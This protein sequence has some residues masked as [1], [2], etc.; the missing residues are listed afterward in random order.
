MNPFDPAYAEPGAPATAVAMER[1][2]MGA[3]GDPPAPM[4]S[5]EVIRHLGKLTRELHEALSGLGYDKKIEAAAQQLPDARERLDHIANLT[6][7]AA[8]RVLGAVEE[9]Q[10]MQ[11]ELHREATSLLERWH[12]G[13]EHG[14]RGVDL[15]D[16]TC[17]FLDRSIAVSAAQS[18][19]LQDIMMAQDFHDLTG[20]V[21]K[22]VGSLAQD[23]EANLLKLLVETFP[24]GPSRTAVGASRKPDQVQSQAEADAL[25]DSLGL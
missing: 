12:A 11:R 15:G 14:H 17:A 5:A 7:L 24:D 2:R 18:E 1:A 22:R 6:W 9:S 4:A 25:L 19:I 10:V 23:L 21:I 13:G 16:D 8:E 20:Q 3:D